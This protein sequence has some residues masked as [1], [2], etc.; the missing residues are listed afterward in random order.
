MKIQAMF[1][2]LVSAAAIAAAMLLAATPVV[3]ATDYKHG[4]E[5]GGKGS[6]HFRNVIVMVPDGC[7]QS[8][9]TLARWYKKR[10]LKD[11]EPLTL[12]GMVSGMVKTHMA[13]S[14]I[15]GSAAAAT[16]FA[17]GYKTTVRFLAVAPISLRRHG[18]HLGQGRRR[19]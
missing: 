10:V 15:T 7:S 3:Q 13:N 19:R 12:D 6:P 11:D 14:V 1:S 8:I 5:D 17:T 9:Q 18:L 16:A 4:A 2:S